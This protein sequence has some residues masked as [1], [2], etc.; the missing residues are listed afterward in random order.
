MP[1]SHPR[2]ALSRPTLAER[3]KSE[4]R[5]DIARIA[6]RLFAEHGTNEVTADRI[7]AEA[8]IALRTFYRYARTKQDAVEPMLTTGA[9]RWFEAI[10]SGPRRLPTLA[11]LESAAV[12]SLTVDDGDDFELTRG[13]LQA[14]E[15]DPALRA[16]WHRINME[17]ERELRRVLTDL[18]GPQADPVHLRL[19]AA[20]AAGA[21]RIS[22]EQWAAAS[23]G[24]EAPA[25]LVVRCMRALGAGV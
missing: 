15:T 10:A 17:G 18:A 25:A 8:G 2:P 20:A 22:L 21:I 19:L 23:A 16:V 14:M 9:Q 12:R 4:T 24:G 7:A 1:V 3:R 11:D 5:L 13:L 6:A